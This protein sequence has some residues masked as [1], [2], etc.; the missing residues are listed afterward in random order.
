ML[1]KQNVALRLLEH[2]SSFLCGHCRSA[3]LRRT[4]PQVEIGREGY[5]SQTKN[6]ENW[7]KGDHGIYEYPWW[8]VRSLS[9][10]DPKATHWG[11]MHLQFE[12][13]LVNI[14]IVAAYNTCKLP[15]GCISLKI[16][17]GFWAPFSEWLPWPSFQQIFSLI[18][19]KPD[20][21]VFHHRATQQKT[22]KIPT[23]SLAI[24]S[25]NRNPWK[26]MYVIHQFLRPPNM[27]QT[28]C[29]YCSI[30][31]I[32]AE[33]R[34]PKRKTCC[35]YLSGRFGNKHRQVCGSGCVFFLK[36]VGRWNKHVVVQ[37]LLL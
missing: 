24:P 27:F 32:A 13:C 35:I 14:Y 19:P 10:N 4:V 16:F 26:Q 11:C 22:F 21:T 3:P 6:I 2:Y 8:S 29:H 9:R 17:I 23:M 28:P 1:K 31:D 37:K 12:C 18:W 30:L 36:A 15:T 20:T 5:I 34:S 33:K 7:G 25:P